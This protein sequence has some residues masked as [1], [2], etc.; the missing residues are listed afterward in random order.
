MQQHHL[1]FLPT[2]GENF[3]HV[4]HEAVQAGCVLLLSDQTP[5]LDLSENQVGWALPLS[6]KQEFVEALT[7]VAGWDESRWQAH[8]N[9]ILSYAFKTNIAGQNAQNHLK[10]FEAVSK[11]HKS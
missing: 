7:D 5:W 2:L 9:S 4:I 8:E 1:F 11:L 10:M 3:G 6:S